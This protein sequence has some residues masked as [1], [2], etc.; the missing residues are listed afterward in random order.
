MASQSRYTSTAMEEHG[1]AHKPEL[2]RVGAL[3]HQV[4]TRLRAIGD[5][6]NQ[7]ADY[8]GENAGSQDFTGAEAERRMSSVVNHLARRLK[9]FL[10]DAS[11][12]TEEIPALSVALEQLRA[13]KRE[14]TRDARGIDATVVYRV[15]QNAAM[16]RRLLNRHA[17]DLDLLG[18]KAARVELGR[19]ARA[20]ESFVVLYDLTRGIELLTSTEQELLTLLE[21]LRGNPL[22]DRAD[23]HDLVGTVKNSLDDYRVSAEQRGITIKLELFCHRAIVNLPREGARK[24]IG[25][26]LDNAIKFTGDLPAASKHKAPW[27][28]VKV[29]V[30]ADSASVSIESWGLPIT[31]EELNNDLLFNYGFRGYF[32]RGF[33]TGSG[34]GLHWIRSF[35]SRYGGS[36]HVS[37]TPTSKAANPRTSTNTTFT[38]M[39]PLVAG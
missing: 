11:S 25:N 14:L 2:E 30:H 38:L 21:E 15:R 26:L 1:S 28:T 5:V 8:V 31:T 20:V 12:S 23:V 33:T 27:V 16:V 29:R 3:V 4:L 6:A 13:L 37:T 9:A 35:V 17:A 34:V 7:V 18:T 22:T 36:V 19:A 10:S 39:F 24:A 32:A